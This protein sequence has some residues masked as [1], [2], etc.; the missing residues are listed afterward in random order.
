MT[1][2]SLD[3]ANINTENP[4]YLIFNNVD[5]HTEQTNGSK[6]L[7]FASTRKNKQVLEKCTELWNE[8]KNQIET[9]NGDEPIKY[10]KDFTKIRFE[11]DDDFPLGKILNIPNMIIVAINLWRSYNM[12][13]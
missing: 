2:K 13:Q 12:L 3:H 9:I 1:M 4:L 8:T 6:Y 10:K 7:I 11:S 5:W